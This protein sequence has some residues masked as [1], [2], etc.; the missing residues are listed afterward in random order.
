[1]SFRF[2]H[3]ADLHL[4]TP[5]EGLGKVSERMA[6]LLRDA[7]L[8]AFD[9][10]VQA[11]IDHEVL[12]VLFAGDIY[13]GESRGVRA[14]LRFLRGFERLAKHGIKSFI[15]HGNH[16]PL[17][18]WSAIRQWPAE[19][20]VFGSSDVAAVPVEVEGRRLATVFGLSYGQREIA[21]NLV[22]RFPKERGTQGSDGLRIGLLHASVGDQPEHS[23]YAPCSLSDLRGAAI[24]YWALGHIH[25][26]AILS[27]G[28]PW[29][30]YSGNTQGRSP[31]PAELGAKGVMLVEA[32]ENQVR[33][34]EFLPTDSV[35]FFNAELDLAD[36]PEGAG[37]AAIATGL[38]ARAQELQT[39]N[40]DLAL[41]IRATIG[42]RGPLHAELAAGGCRDEFLRDLR[43]SF[44]DVEPPLWWEDLQDRTRAAID[45]EVVRSRDDF[46]SSVVKRAEIWLADPAQLG[47]VAEFLTPSSPA[48]FRR[49][50]GLADQVETSRLVE[51]AMFL[52]VESL[53]DEVSSC[54]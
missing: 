37:L 40:P 18:G 43:D 53:E 41:L 17:G 50:C 34:A 27:E 5:F 33:S 16:D 49:R 20:T 52:A 25:R 9:K 31:K 1:M 46:T 21:E 39:L 48:E 3:A 35:R 4:D 13:D 29:V 2:I 7:S 38:A 24:D 45:L 12:F 54:D 22:L 30:V 28:R 32:D 26:R 23:S 19:V 15:V 44:A 47:R 6:T 8:D 42:G 36:L 14:Q 11:A 10:V 51:A